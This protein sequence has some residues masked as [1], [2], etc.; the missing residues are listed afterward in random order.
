MTSTVLKSASYIFH[1][2]WLPTYAMLYYF[3]EVNFM[4][5]YESMIA[6]I[7]A[8]IILTC[9]LPILFL[10]MLKPLKLIE[11][12]HLS[13]VEQ[14]RIPLLFFLT[15]TAVITN[16]IFDPVEYRIPF[17]FFSAVFFSGI[18]CFLLTFFKH[19][20]SLHAV[21]IS[22]F[23]VFVI[24]FNIE[25]GLNGV[26]FASLCIVITGWVVAS[27]LYMGAHTIFELITGL[28]LGVVS[29]LLFLEYWNMS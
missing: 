13:K 26:G 28:L 18:I 6:K 12:L 10:L 3:S 14:R 7:F 8:V 29:Q 24:V 5:T 21:G 15:I 11:D 25:Y 22:T 20:I 2:L 27:R 4:Y 16:F 19:K 9:I 23:S 17:Y 1:P